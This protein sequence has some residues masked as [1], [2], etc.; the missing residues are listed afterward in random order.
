MNANIYSPFML[1]CVHQ[2]VTNFVCL[3][4]GAVV[5]SGFTTGVMLKAGANRNEVDESGETEPKQ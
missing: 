4:C 1:P 2:L 3:L 5:Y